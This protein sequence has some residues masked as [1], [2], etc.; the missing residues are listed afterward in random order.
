MDELIK[1]LLALAEDAQRT[2][3]QI[4]PSMSDYSYEEGRITAYDHAADLVRAAKRHM[5]ERETAWN[6][7]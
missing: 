6:L 3:D 4:D 5:A 1:E 2:R 7:G